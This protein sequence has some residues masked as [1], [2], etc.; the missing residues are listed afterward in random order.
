MIRLV[1]LVQTQTEFFCSS[2][3]NHDRTSLWQLELWFVGLYELEF[4]M[5]LKNIMC[6]KYYYTLKYKL[7]CQ[8]KEN[9]C[10]MQVSRLDGDFNNLY[11]NITR[12]CEGTAVFTVFKA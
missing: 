7:S 4:K 3:K 12:A 2:N 6:G 10:K 5:Q 9:K 11:N 1:R 8:L